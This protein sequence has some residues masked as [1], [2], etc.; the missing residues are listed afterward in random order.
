[1]K[2]TPRKK[3]TAMREEKRQAPRMRLGYQE[4]QAEWLVY[5]EAAGECTWGH[6]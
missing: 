5:S 3:Q 1:M 4:D 2:E 6:V